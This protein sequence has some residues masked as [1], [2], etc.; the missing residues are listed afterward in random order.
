[1]GSVGGSYDNAM[2]EAL[3][4]SLKRELVDVS[5]PRTI[6]EAR[7]AIFEW[8]NW[9]NRRRLHSSLGYIT[10]EEFEESMLRYSKA[11]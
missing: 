9:Y 8:V 5:H 10:P 11:A 6:A 7:A 3:W 1:M 4:S 2:A